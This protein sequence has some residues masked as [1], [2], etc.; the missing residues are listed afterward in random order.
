MPSALASRG[1]FGLDAMLLHVVVAKARRPEGLSLVV[2]A[3]TVAQARYLDQLALTSYGF[4]AL[5][6]ASKLVDLNGNDL[7]LTLAGL[8][9]DKRLLEMENASKRLFISEEGLSLASI[10]GKSSEF[11]GWMYSR[12]VQT[13]AMEVQPPAE[14]KGWLYGAAERMLP[15]EFMG[16]FDQNRR[17]SLCTIAFELLENAAQH[18]RYDERGAKLK[19]GIRGLNLRLVDVGLGQGGH[20]AGGNPTVN[21]YFNRTAQKGSRQ[22]NRYLELTVF[23]SGI[24]FHKWLNAACNDNERTR[25]YRGMAVKD[26]V[27]S[28]VFMHA[29]SKGVDGT[30]IGLYRAT[31]LLKELFGFVRI[32]T[33]TECYFARLDQTLAGADR[34]LGGDRE[35]AANPIVELEEWYPGRSLK[36]AGGSSVTFG[37]PLIKW[38]AR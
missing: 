3:E 17:E 9:K 32:R 7:P 36:D 11:A 29:S 30:G 19:K 24:G 20:L 27:R 15:D 35:D 28:C 1:A 34:K 6:L 33:G 14:L 23:D 4:A 2:P 8:R 10:Y 13:G 37:I 26:T 22:E 38:S 18:G 25:P 5:A 12:S 31:R 21:M 16:L